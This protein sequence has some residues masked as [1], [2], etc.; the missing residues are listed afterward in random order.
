LVF[1]FFFQFF[2]FDFFF[3]SYRNNVISGQNIIRNGG[4]PNFRLRMGA[5]EGTPLGSRHFR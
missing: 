1:Y 3:F 2:F 4:N 5:Y